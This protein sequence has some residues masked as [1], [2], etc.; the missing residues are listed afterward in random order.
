M[1]VSNTQCFRCFFPLVSEKFYFRCASNRP[2]VFIY[3]SIL[4]HNISENCLFQNE[5]L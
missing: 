5:V 1:Y 3:L 2:I 4:H